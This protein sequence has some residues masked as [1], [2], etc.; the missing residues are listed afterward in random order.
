MYLSELNAELFQLCPD[1]QLE[2]DNY[3]QI[4]IYTGLMKD[5]LD[6][7]DGSVDPNLRDFDPEDA[8]Q[9]NVETAQVGQHVWKGASIVDDCS[10]CGERYAHP[11]HHSSAECSD[12]PGGLHDSSLRDD[13][14]NG[15][16]P[17]DDGIDYDDNESNCQYGDKG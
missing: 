1:F 9:E 10:L 17:S 7:R 13:D 11:S 15:C 8:E 5:P 2:V 3:G 14:C 16:Y 6:I 4:I 12:H